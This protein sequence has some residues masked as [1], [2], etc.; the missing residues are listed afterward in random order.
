MTADAL[1][2]QRE[3][4][5]YLVAE[6][7]ADYTLIVKANQPNLF[8]AP[9]ALNWDTPPLH[10]KEETGHGRIE[11]RMIR[12]QPAPDGITFPYVAQVFL[13]ERYVTDTDTGS[14]TNTAIAVL[15]TTRRDATA[16]TPSR[17]PPG[18]AN[19][20]ASRTPCTTSE[21]SPTAKTPPKPRRQRTRVMAS[22]RNL[23]IGILRLAGKTTIA[24]GLRHTARG[25]IRPLQ[26]LRLHP[27][28]RTAVARSQLDGELRKPGMQSGLVSVAAG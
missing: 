2:A 25:F 22:I 9:D 16:Q 5:T 26:L 28:F 1:H 20:G 6:R 14:G 7:G 10:T 12:V 11:R 15:G 21:T 4:A 27:R 24:A 19:T 18:H 23:A 3:H 17:S 8:T 13:I